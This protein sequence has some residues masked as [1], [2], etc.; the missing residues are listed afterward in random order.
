MLFNSSS[1]ECV[2]QGKV[3]RV[4]NGAKCIRLRLICSTETEHSALL[5][6]AVPTPCFQEMVFA[7]GVL[8]IVSPFVP[9]AGIR[10]VAYSPIETCV[11]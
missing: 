8:W 6:L 10:H 2:L 3:V 5:C 11:S 1:S 7:T 9:V 4:Q